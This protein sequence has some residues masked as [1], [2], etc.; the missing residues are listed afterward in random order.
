[1]SYRIGISYVGQLQPQIDSLFVTPRLCPRNDWCDHRTFRSCWSTC[2]PCARGVEHA[3]TPHYHR[4]VAG[5]L[6]TSA[7][8][9]KGRNNE[10]IF[11]IRPPLVLTRATRNKTRW[12]ALWLHTSS[13]K[14]S[15]GRKERAHW[16]ST[17]QFPAPPLPQPTVSIA[18][19]KGPQSPQKLTLASR[20]RR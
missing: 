5:P 6:P 18:Y 17:V 20:S 15:A 10:K 7:S 16:F 11:D 13:C 4:P 12:R 1:L 2:L 19:K 8:T 3:I 9:S 14:L